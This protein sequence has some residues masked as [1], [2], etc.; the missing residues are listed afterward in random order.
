MGRRD[1]RMEREEGRMMETG[2]R[3]LTLTMKTVSLKVAVSVQ[4]SMFIYM[5]LL[6]MCSIKTTPPVLQLWSGAPSHLA[7]FQFLQFP[8]AELL[9][10]TE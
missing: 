8:L 6:K 7:Q 3:C 5:K 4:S 2:K 10:L 1:T 9:M